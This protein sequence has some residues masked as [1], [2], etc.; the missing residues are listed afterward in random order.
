MCSTHWIPSSPSVT[1]LELDSVKALYVSC[2]YFAKASFNTGERGVVWTGQLFHLIFKLT[3]VPSSIG[4]L[5]KCSSLW[6]LSTSQNQ[7]FKLS[8]Y[9]LFFKFIFRKSTKLSSGI[10]SFRL[11]KMQSSLSFGNLTNTLS[12]ICMT[13]WGNML[14]PG[15][16]TELVFRGTEVTLR[17]SW[18]IMP[19]T[20]NLITGQSNVTEKNKFIL[21]KRYM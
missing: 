7:M 9:V 8:L 6:V 4:M 20:G 17:L 11:R 18:D 15:F 14:Q 5:S 3:W 1:M 12:L 16:V 13:S 2:T 21:P 19:Y 10:V